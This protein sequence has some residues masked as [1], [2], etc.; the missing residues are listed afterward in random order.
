MA[1]STL[2]VILVG[3]MIALLQVALAGGGGP[4]AGGRWPRTLAVALLYLVLPAWL[5]MSGHLDAQ[6]GP[7]PLAMPLILG[8]T[9]LTVAASFSAAGHRVATALPL[10]ALVGLQVFRLPLE[11]LLHRLAAAGEIPMV[12]TY[13]GWN[14]DIVTGLTALVLG[15]WLVRGRVPTALVLGWNVMGLVLLVTIVT[16][17]VL[18]APGPLQRFTDGPP[19]LLP[20]CFPYVWLPTV[21]VQLALA[22]HLLVFRRL[23]MIPSGRAWG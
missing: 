18:A 10:A 22:G 20:V 19:N 8:L 2:F 23:R 15:L 6:V 14:F 5:A 21:L 1:T 11:L 3:V 9:V 4:T 17:S 13:A 12:M 16:I 7:V